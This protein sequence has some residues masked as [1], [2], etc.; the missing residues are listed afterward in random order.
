MSSEWK[1]RS[2][3]KRMYYLAV[4]CKFFLHGPNNLQS[5]Y[6]IENSRKCLAR[7]DALA[8]VCREHVL[9]LDEN[10]HLVFTHVA[11]VAGDRHDGVRNW[12]VDA[13]P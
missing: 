6:S 10:L 7:L 8:Q 3:E 4:L 1:G 12:R 11:K 2:R 5:E 9:R 13:T